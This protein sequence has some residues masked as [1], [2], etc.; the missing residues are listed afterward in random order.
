MGNE[1]IDSM[2]TINFARAHV[3]MPYLQHVIS[4]G[5]LD[6]LFELH[7]WRICLPLH[8]S[9]HRYWWFCC[10]G[11]ESIMC[12]LFILTWLW[13]C[14]CQYR[15]SSCVPSDR[16]EAPSLLPWYHLSVT[17]GLQTKRTGSFNFCICL[18]E[19]YKLNFD[20]RHQQRIIHK[21]R[22]PIKTRGFLCDDATVVFT[23]PAKPWYKSRVLSKRI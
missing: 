9:R 22:L 18:V 4:D 13:T 12:Q 10:P 1:Q 7:Q 23:K 19:L 6:E 8:P 21:S 2:S 20:I 3:R 16:D 14:S 15:Y 5:K 17:S 11:G